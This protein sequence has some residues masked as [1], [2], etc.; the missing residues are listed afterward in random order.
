MLEE[1]KQQKRLAARSMQEIMEEERLRQEILAQY[2]D[3][4]EATLSLIRQNL[5]EAFDIT[6]DV[7]VEPTVI[8]A[9][10]K[11]QR[12]KSNRW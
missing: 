2:G 12:N 4:D 6:Q 5:E 10:S 7:A 3:C 1:C 11:K 8:K 9:V